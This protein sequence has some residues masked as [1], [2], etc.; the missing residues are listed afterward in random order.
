MVESLSSAEMEGVLTRLDTAISELCISGLTQEQTS[1]VLS[2]V[3]FLYANECERA[4][5]AINTAC[6][7]YYKEFAPQISQKDGHRDY[8]KYARSVIPAKVVLAYTSDISKDRQ[9]IEKERREFSSNAN[10]WALSAGRNG[11]NSRAL[12]SGR[13]GV[14]LGRNEFSRQNGANS[15]NGE[16][17]KQ[18]GVSQRAND[19]SSISWGEVFN[20]IADLA[21]IAQF[22]L[23]F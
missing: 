17:S 12:D 5:N 2:D 18:N 21:T 15:K 22:A 7:T 23:K 16:F 14:N 9:R 4:Q 3:F 8:L 19:E 11:A 13:N 10:L 1:V 20:L 6:D